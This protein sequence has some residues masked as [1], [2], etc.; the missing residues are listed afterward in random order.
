MIRMQQSYCDQEEKA[1]KLRMAVQEN[2]RIWVLMMIVP[3]VTCLCISCF[4]RKIHLFWLGHC[5]I[6]INTLSHLIL[7]TNSRGR[8]SYM[9]IFQRRKLKLREV[10]LVCSRSM[11]R[12]PSVSFQICPYY[13]AIPSAS[14]LHIKKG[15]NPILVSQQRASGVG[16]RGRM[17]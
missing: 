1:P 9:P 16:V 8:H 6:Q 4:V 11:A 2:R 7:T 5:D 12:A 14:S 17:I 10:K 3:C 15:F 13:Y